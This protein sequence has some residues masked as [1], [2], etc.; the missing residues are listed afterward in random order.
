MDRCSL[1]IGP[2]CRMEV[3]VEQIQKNRRSNEESQWNCHQAK[4]D[5]N[6][7]PQHHMATNGQ[8]ENV[9]KS[10]TLFLGAIIRVVLRQNSSNWMTGG[11]QVGIVGLVDFV[12]GWEELDGV[13]E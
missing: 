6:V 1:E 9:L 2:S 4:L 12:V 10:H 13:G 11:R 5:S 7:L 8:I 3:Q